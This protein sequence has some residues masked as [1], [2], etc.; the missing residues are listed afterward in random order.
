MYCKSCGTKCDENALFC[1]SCGNKM[2]RKSEIRSFDISFNK[3]G[4]VVIGI[5]ILF[6]ILCIICLNILAKDEEERLPN[7]NSK[8]Q[9]FEKENKNI[10][11]LEITN[12]ESIT[13]MGIYPELRQIKSNGSICFDGEFPQL[14]MLECRKIV[15]KDSEQLNNSMFPELKEVS[16]TLNN[17]EIDENVI[18][19]INMFDEMV[20]AGKLSKFSKTFS[21]TIEDLYGEW[22]DS[23]NLLSICLQ[24]DGEV[25]IADKTG[26]IGV[27]L[28][29]YKMEGNNTLSL[30]AIGNDFLNMLSINIE[31]QLLGD[32]M[33]ITLLGKTFEMHRK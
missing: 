25:R 2:E 15:F 24:K 9:S 13:L 27:E 20:R 11:Y 30:K 17:D 10:E 21:H 8:N 22:V 5:V 32:N 19:L 18:N 28:M 29:T 14:E 3:T 16:I 23:N 12:E 4:I 26:L 7:S 6:V 33:T 1:K 31:Y